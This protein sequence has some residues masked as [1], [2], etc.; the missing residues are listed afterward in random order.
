MQ[1]GQPCKGLLFL[2]KSSV[3]VSGKHEIAH[4]Y[5]LTSA[6]HFSKK[7]AYAPYY[8]SAI[9]IDLHCSKQ[10]LCPNILI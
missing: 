7:Y 5:H 6:P 4:V 10:Q 8:Y 3:R 1:K 9:C 2:E